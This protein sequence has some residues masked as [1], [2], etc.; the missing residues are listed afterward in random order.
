MKK[1][2]SA[3]AIILALISMANVTAYAASVSSEYVCDKSTL[4]AFYCVTYTL[5]SIPDVDEDDNIRLEL[6]GV[7]QNLS[8]GRSR[9]VTLTHVGNGVFKGIIPMYKVGE[10]E[11]SFYRLDVTKYVNAVTLNDRGEYVSTLLTYNLGWYSH[12]SYLYLVND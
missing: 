5:D 4:R 3:L 12:S 7:M 9:S 2:V 10:Y 8:T 6:V 1:I 11:L